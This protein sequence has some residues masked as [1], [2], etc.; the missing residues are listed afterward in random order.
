MDRNLNQDDGNRPEKMD[1]LRKNKARI[2]QKYHPEI[3]SFRAA[4]VTS[5]QFMPSRAKSLVHIWCFVNYRKL[6]FLESRGLQ[7]TPFTLPT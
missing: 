2:V 6:Q 4:L 7:W 3:K 5:C 1:T